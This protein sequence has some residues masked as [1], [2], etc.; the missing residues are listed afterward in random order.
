MYMTLLD[1]ENAAVKQSPQPEIATPPVWTLEATRY[2]ARKIA[3]WIRNTPY[4]G[5]RGA[6][7]GS[8]KSV[9]FNLVYENPPVNALSRFASQIVSSGDHDDRNKPSKAERLRELVAK[10]SP[11]FPGHES[12]LCSSGGREAVMITRTT[13]GLGSAAVHELFA[14]EKVAQV[15]ALNRRSSKNQSLRERQRSILRCRG[16]IV[17]LVDSDKVCLLEVNMALP[18]FALDGKLYGEGRYMRSSVTRIIHNAY[19]VDF[20]ISLSSFKP[21]L[22]IVRNIID[23]ALSS[24]LATPPAIRCTSRI[25]VLGGTL[26]VIS[27]FT[28]LHLIPSVPARRVEPAKE[29]PLEVPSSAIWNGYSESK[30]TAERIL[31]R[32]SAAVPALRTTVVRVGQLA[33]GK[34]GDW[35]TAEWLPS[36]I[37]SGAKVQCLPSQPSFTLA[38]IDNIAPVLHLAHPQPVAWDMVMKH[39]SE[40]LGV[41]LISYPQTPLTDPTKTELEHMRDHPATRLLPF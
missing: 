24:H 8:E 2:F 18:R 1:Q 4:R 37:A 38:G 17:D 15:Y 41:P 30:W 23:F 9:P 11:D 5:M 10:Y 25:A 7:R 21:Q 19:P 20:N 35:N 33:G 3:T 14:C 27:L 16:L 12:V 40:R 22:L 29:T 6:I 34:T 32:A 13:G 26:H 31:Q 28:V 36:L 39:V